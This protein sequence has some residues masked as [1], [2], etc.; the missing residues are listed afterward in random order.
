MILKNERFLELKKKKSEVAIL[1]KKL[2]ETE[3]PLGV[4][5]Y[6]DFKL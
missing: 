1:G 2:W 3:D 4:I 5:I 6:P